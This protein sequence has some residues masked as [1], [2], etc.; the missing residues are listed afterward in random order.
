MYTREFDIPYKGSEGKNG[1][2]HIKA[3]GFASTEE[4]M[5]CIQSRPVPD[6][7]SEQDFMHMEPDKELRK[8]WCGCKTVGEFREMLDYGVTDVKKIQEM[9]KFIRKACEGVGPVNTRANRVVGGSVNVGRYMT[10][11]PTCMRGRIKD[12]RPDKTLHVV[13]DMDVNCYVDGKDLLKC[14]RYVAAAIDKVQRM[15]YNMKITVGIFTLCHEGRII[16]GAVTLK[17][18]GTR[19]SLPRLLFWCGHPSAFRCGC[20]NY[21]V[22]RD[23]LPRSNYHGLGRAMGGLPEVTC[24]AIYQ[25]AFPGCISLNFAQ[26]INRYGDSKDEVWMEALQ[27]LLLEEY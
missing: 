17:P 22:G 21:L 4:F 6:L 24:G 1:K 2:L 5:K 13:I 14:S 7:L 10:G 15:G 18:F 23:D 12:E 3:E 16:I 11:I 9:Q 20:F 27:R 26:L 19:I 8:S 25:K